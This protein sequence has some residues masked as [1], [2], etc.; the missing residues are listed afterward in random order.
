MSD[1]IM[2]KT[3]LAMRARRRDMAVRAAFLLLALLCLTGYAGTAAD[4]AMSPVHEGNEDYLKRSLKHAGAWM[5]GLLALRAG[6]SVVES[7]S[8]E[9]MGVGFEAG[10]VVEPVNDTLSDIMD[11]MTMNA[12]LIVFQLAVL[13]TI[14]AISL[15]YLLGTGALLCVISYSRLSNTG[16]LGLMLM[17]L[18]L[19]LYIVYPLALNMASGVF[20]EHQARSSVEFSESVG[21]LTERARDVYPNLMEG[22]LSAAGLRDTAGAFSRMLSEG[23]RALWEGL[24]GL[25]TSFAIMFVLAPLMSVGVSYLCLRQAMAR[26]DM[27]L[28]IMDRKA[29]SLLSARPGGGADA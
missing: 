25:M 11:L 19:V 7:L 4:M 27:P 17:V 2:E 14:K 28:L 9:P 22:G 26:L 5:A 29:Q 3:A 8:L 12:L 15:K 13:D 23:T 21:V 24:W 6:V 18:G 1:A 16:R 10:R 20:E